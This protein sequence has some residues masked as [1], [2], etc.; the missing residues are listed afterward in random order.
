MTPG[1][2]RRTLVIDEN[3]NPRLATELTRRG[4][5]ATTVQALGLRGS[6]DPHLLD[7]LDA[8][9]D[10]WILV[11]ADDALPGSHAEAVRRVGAT[12]GTVNPELEDG[13]TLESWRRE[14]VPRWAHALHDQEG[15]T[16]RRYS[17]RRHAVWRVRRRRPRP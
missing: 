17:L 10:D 13:W 2:P 15:G 1:P 12:I 7:K 11:T 8:K 9:L 16:I 14:I 4:R 5:N 6:E 3:L